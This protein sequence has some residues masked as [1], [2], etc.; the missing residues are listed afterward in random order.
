MRLF[1][2][3]TKGRHNPLS[4]LCLKSPQFLQI[5]ERHPVLFSSTQGAPGERG[6]SGA[7]GPKGA[8][9]DPGRPGESGLPGA[10]VSADEK[11]SKEKNKA[12]ILNSKSKKIKSLVI[13]AKTFKQEFVLKRFKDPVFPLEA[14]IFKVRSDF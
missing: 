3:P 5:D 1:P 10:R 4:Y 11:K 7:S 6:P 14:A 9:G 13:R 12:E 8:N 2:T